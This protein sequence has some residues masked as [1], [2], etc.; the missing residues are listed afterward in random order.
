MTKLIR[1]IFIFLSL[2]ILSACGGGGGSAGN[3]SG[4]AALFVSAGTTVLISPGQSQTYTIGGGVPTYTATTTSGAVSVSVNGT[5][6][7]VTGNVGGGKATVVVKDAK[8]ASVSFD[9][10]V[11]SGLALFTTAP[12]AVAVGVGATSSSYSIG[13]GS[14]VYAV[15][16]SNTGVAAIAVNNR[17]NSQFVIIGVSAGTATISVVD[18]H[19]AAVT[20]TVTVGTTSTVTPLFTTAASAIVIPTN[21]VSTFTIGGGTAPYFASSSNTA[22]ATINISGNNLTINGLAAGSAT[23]VVSDT[24]GTQVKIVITVGNGGVVAALFTTAPS[25]VNLSTNAVITFT[26]GGGSAPYLASSSNSAIAT[27]S[28]SGTTLSISGLTAGVAKIVVSDAAGTAVAITVT[29][30]T[31]STVTP[32]FTTAAST[33]VVS[34]N[35]VSTFTVGG[36]VA[37]YFASSSNTAVAAVNLTGNTLTINGLLAGSATVVVSDAVGTQVKI[38][39]TVGNGGVVA[40]LFTTAPSAINLPTNAVTTFTIGGGSAPYFASSSNSAIATATASGTT[41]TV[42]GLTAGSAKIVV[43]DAAGNAVTITVTVGNVGVVPPLFTTAPSAI[44]LASNAVTA[45]TIG[46]GTGPYLASSSSASVATASVNGTTLTINGLLA[47][48]AK[49]VVSDNVGASV[50]I[51]VTVGNIG[52][53]TP[54][55]T[56]APSTIV[57]GI[58]ATSTFTVGG[59][60]P[61]YLAS[62]SNSSVLSASLTGTTLNLKGLLAGTATVLVTDA[63]GTPVSIAVTVGSSVPSIPLFTSAVST[64][65][66]ATNSSSSFTI[67][68]GTAP[69]LVS[70]SNVAVANAAIS[71]TNLTIN[72]FSSGTAKIVV[73]DT[74]GATVTITVTVGSSG[75]TVPLFTTAASDIVISANGTSNFTIGGGLGPYLVSSSAP[76]VVSASVSGSALTINGLI[77]GTSKVVVT[78]ANGSVATINVSVTSTTQPLVTTAASDIVVAINSSS[79]YAISGGLAP[80]FASSSNTSVVV[81]SVNGS[82]LVINGLLAGTG[83][84]SIRDSSGLTISINVSVGKGVPVT[85]FTSAPSIITIGQGASPNYT[86]GGGTAP[87]TAGSSN[88]AVATVTLAGSSLVI[89]GVAPG[90]ANI[91]VTDNVGATVTIVVT[92]IATTSTTLTVSPSTVIA[93]A[94]DTLAFRID[95]GS[96]PYSV[97]S[98]NSAIATIPNNSVSA[99]GGTFTAFLAKP[100]SVS[101]VVA[102]ATGLTQTI[103]ITVN[104]AISNMFLSPSD[105]SISE[106][107]NST[108]NLAIKGGNGPFQVFTTN[109]ILSSVSGTLPQASNV[110]TFDGTTVGVAIG[111]QGTRCVSSDTVI[112]IVVKDSLG[113]SATSNMTIK[114]KNGGA[115]C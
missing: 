26:I 74:A 58:S 17:N 16:S 6:L 32:L 57:V 66:L 84:V 56:T 2:A 69:Y 73:S 75:A 77:A 53:I 99:S 78:D 115:G 9:V 27:A 88:V 85:L 90:T 19:G 63:T 20:I 46:G 91:V 102:D 101:I 29:V 113:Q 79:T 61:P 23:V 76:S 72:G 10:T 107:N 54:L 104:V 4:G 105:W 49:I 44:T 95:G 64:I 50:S 94:G 67:G 35:S 98:N 93:Y 97:I 18:S 111:S 108:V 15:T 39:V 80:Y 37:S 36:G 68:G 24:A 92:V 59:G 81:P 52:P 65:S 14:L 43:S 34:T 8:G 30:G 83:K 103:N 109:T 51:T 87:Y 12:A 112:S 110:L 62:S 45:F 70:S 96:A 100:G 40:A 42:N 22:V 25:A 1:T 3:T 33:I 86:I 47:G 7:N 114:D 11:G 82:T 106:T 28:V 41:L 31:T 38:G 13:G 48:T 55:F 60:T 71:G 21:S 89:N 5:A